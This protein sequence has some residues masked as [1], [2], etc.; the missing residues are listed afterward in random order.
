MKNIESHVV[1]LEDEKRRFIGR[2]KRLSSY[3]DRFAHDMSRKECNLRTMARM[4]LDAFCLAGYAGDVPK[5]VMIEHLH[6]AQFF[7]VKNH[8]RDMVPQDA[9]FSFS[10]GEREFALAGTEGQFSVEPEDWLNSIA[11]SIITGRFD[12]LIG[13]MALEE[14]WQLHFDSK[15]TQLSTDLFLHCLELKTSEDLSALL[16]GLLAEIEA[17]RLR[18]DRIELALAGLTLTLGFFNVMLAA[19]THDETGYREA[20]NKAI[21]L[22]KEWFTHDDDFNNRIIGYVSI[23]LL[24]AAKYAYVKYGFTVGVETPYLPTFVFMD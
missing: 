12:D 18:P 24:A 23:P 19:H 15:Q 22:H 8:G 11:L 6:N 2:T 1:N 5:D 3:K 17:N 13:L 21:E 10:Y 4:E 14:T 20:M 9:I 16:D 7:A